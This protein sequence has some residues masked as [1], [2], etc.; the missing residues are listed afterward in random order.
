MQYLLGMYAHLKL[1]QIRITVART[2]HD[3][4]LT[5]LLGGNRRLAYRR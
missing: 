2:A 1:P 5:F 4:T 3:D